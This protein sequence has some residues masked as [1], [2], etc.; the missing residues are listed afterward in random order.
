MVLF[1]TVSQLESSPP[2]AD[3][4]HAI[5]LVVG[6]TTVGCESGGPGKKVEF[7]NSSLLRLALSCGHHRKMHLSTT[8]PAAALFT[9]QVL[10]Q[11][12][13]SAQVYLLPI[14]PIHQH[15]TPAL[16]QFDANSLISHHLGFDAYNEAEDSNESWWNEMSSWITNGKVGSHGVGEGSQDAVLIVI[17]SDH[18][19]G[20][21][22]TL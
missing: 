16:N 21:W 4:L 17:Q 5:T 2:E 19:E 10:A 11:A 9:A 7:D 15:Q 1:Q 12:G 6:S 3:G 22:T 20:G 14:G 18:P 13:P 8:L